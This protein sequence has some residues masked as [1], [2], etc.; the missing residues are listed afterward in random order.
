MLRLFTRLYFFI[1]V[2]NLFLF[3]SP[4]KAQDLPIILPTNDNLSNLFNPKPFITVW[5]ASDINKLFRKAASLQWQYPDSAIALYN[6]A[7]EKSLAIHYYNGAARANIEMGLTRLGQGNFEACIAYYRQAYPFILRSSMRSTLLSTLYINVGAAYSYQ[8]NYQKAFEYYYATLQYLLQKSG[9]PYNTIMTYNNIAD[10]LAHME[11]YDKEEYYL[12]QGE[13]MMLKYKI[14]SIYGFI[15]VNKADLALI[16][17][18][19]TTMQHYLNNAEESAL[20]HNQNE[21]LQSVY[22][23]WAKYYLNTG[24]PRQAIEAVSKALKKEMSAY[25]FYSVIEP[26][27]LLGF[28]YYQ[29]HDYRA[30]EQALLTALNKADNIGIMSDQLAAVATLSA[31]YEQTGKPAKALKYARRYNAL[32]DT[33]HNQEKMKIANELEIKYRTAQKDKDLVSKK[34]L[35]EHQHRE[36]E[37]KNLQVFSSLIGL[38]L[39]IVIA[40]ILY[41]NFRHKNK[42]V[43]LKSRVEGEDKERSRIARELHDGIGGMLAVVKMKLTSGQGAAPDDS[44]LAL[45]NQTAEEIRKTAHNLMPDN[46]GNFSLENALT[47]YVETINRASPGLKIDLQIHSG[48]HIKDTSASLSLYRML[49]EIIQ[50]IIKHARADLAVIQVFE[51]SGKLRFLIEDNGIGFDE[52]LVKKGLGLT[53]LEAHI[54][55]LNGKLQLHSVPGGG[56]TI[57]IELN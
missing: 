18:D 57:N 53:N 19:Y 36:L 30:A 43:A 4:G 45:L 14:K 11:Q 13:Q 5:N 46:I 9:D 31:I 10:V 34:L 44:V 39:A 8:G 3:P 26:Y 35:I 20:A 2:G 29:V 17:K 33:V 28:A 54:K 49:Q 48:I 21:V 55:I 52:K 50:N 38:L 40:F 42:I 32:R 6:V 24:R 51:Q 37:R 41:R 15:W 1:L 12:N 23:T 27:Y 7:L 25:P 22:V 47:T 56:T 16:R